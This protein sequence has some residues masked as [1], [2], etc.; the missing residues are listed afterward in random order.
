MC[1]NINKNIFVYVHISLNLNI[2]VYVLSSWTPQHSG[3]NCVGT[4]SP[5]H[6]H[7]CSLVAHTNNS[8]RLQKNPQRRKSNSN[9]RTNSKKTLEPF[10]FISA[11]MVLTKKHVFL[12]RILKHLNE[13]LLEVRHQNFENSLRDMPTTTTA[14]NVAA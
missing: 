3:W 2:F 10:E 7:V 14:Q 4:N 6:M 9:L 5:Q 11:R 8:N 12:T 13:Y 1:V